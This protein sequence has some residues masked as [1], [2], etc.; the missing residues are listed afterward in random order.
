MAVM[1]TFAER[2]R[3]D[4]KVFVLR[5]VQP[6]LVGLIDGTLS[7]LAP[8]FAA[9][10]LAGSHAALL[11]GLA[12]ALGAGISM[13][14][15]EALSDDGKQTDRGTGVIRG[16]VTGGMTTLGGVFHALPFLISHRSTAIGVALFV[17]LL[18]LIAISVIR[19][20]FLAIS[21]RN[22]FIQVT[23]G[24]IL[25]LAVGLLLGGA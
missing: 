14:L 24:G 4:E 25:I 5:Y 9:A 18:E 23:I 3:V 11:I 12:T 13:G 8:V 15:S 19:K 17:V 1:S 21:L 7:T 20:R 22:S 6:G 10:V 16:L 2:L